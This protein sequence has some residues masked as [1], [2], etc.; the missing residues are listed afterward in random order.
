MFE[1]ALYMNDKFEFNL[2]KDYDQFFLIYDYAI[3]LEE[4]CIVNHN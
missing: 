2:K 4:V 3:I 1:H